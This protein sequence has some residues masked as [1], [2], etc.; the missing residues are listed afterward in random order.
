MRT[1]CIPIYMYDL[2]KP[3]HN[4][5]HVKSLNKISAFVAQP[6]PQTVADESK[7]IV[8]M[9]S[10]V[11][12]LTNSQA[13]IWADSLIVSLVVPLV[14]PVT[15]RLVARSLSNSPAKPIPSSQPRPCDPSPSAHA[16]VDCTPSQSTLQSTLTAPHYNPLLMNMYKSSLKK[17]ECNPSQSTPNPSKLDSNPKHS[18]RTLTKPNYRLGEPAAAPTKPHTKSQSRDVGIYASPNL[19]LGTKPNPRTST[20]KKPSSSSTSKCPPPFNRLPLAALGVDELLDFDVEENTWDN[21]REAEIFIIGAH[22]KGGRLIVICFNDN[23]ASD[24]GSQ[25]EDF[26]S[27]CKLRLSRGCS[28]KQKLLTVMEIGS[29]CEQNGKDFKIKNPDGHTSLSQ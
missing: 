3:S 28:W 26:V 19:T 15:Y 25:N 7:Q 9:V 1:K 23:P 17:P 12:D 18:S 29:S 16:K 24:D 11:E 21:G 2:K 5:K 13:N 27:N 6:L 22:T 14:K 20:L 8:R 4:Q 10:G